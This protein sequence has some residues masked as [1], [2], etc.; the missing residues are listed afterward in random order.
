M[1]ATKKAVLFASALGWLV[2]APAQG[3]SIVLTFQ[4]LKKG[5]QILNYYNAGLGDMNSGPGPA[6]GVTFTSNATMLNDEKHYIGEPS[7]PE[8]MLLGNN[9]VPGG[10]PVGATMN[11]A[12][13]FVSDLFFYYGAIEGSTR[14]VP[15]AVQIYSGADGTGMQLAS[16]NLPMTPG[17]NTTGPLAVFTAAPVDIPFAGIAHSVVFTGGN[18]QIVFDN[19]QFTPA[20]PE[21]GTLVLLAEGCLCVLVG[22][23][24]RRR[25]VTARGPGGKR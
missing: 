9:T 14:D 1:K 20:I 19:I 17:S 10:S 15:Q 12:G 18:Q 6:F 23:G 3:A 4:G 13:G 21:P 7:A 8:V 25:L 24:L 5:E 16:M 22:L 11:V 2:C